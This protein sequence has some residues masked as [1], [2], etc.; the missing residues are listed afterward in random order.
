MKLYIVGKKTTDDSADKSWEFQGVFSTEQKAVAACLTA[1]YFV[2]P[3][4][5]DDA[6]PDATTGW[7]GAYY[8]IAR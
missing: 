1:F 6:F 8:P 7:V 2:G 5:L 4:D 3:A